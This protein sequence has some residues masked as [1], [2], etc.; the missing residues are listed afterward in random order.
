MRP[1]LSLLI[2]QNVVGEEV[3]DKKWGAVGATGDGTEVG[4]HTGSLL[5]GGAVWQTA[6]IDKP[7]NQTKIKRN[8]ATFVINL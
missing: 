6:V 7:P 2:G 8:L 4:F 3:E 5:G 1:R